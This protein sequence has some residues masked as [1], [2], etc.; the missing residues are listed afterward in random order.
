MKQRLGSLIFISVFATAVGAADNWPEYRGPTADGHSDAT[1]LPLHWS[2]TENIAWKTPIHD[3]GWS[4]PV[5]WGNKIWLTT[6]TEDGKKYYALAIDAGTGKILHDIKLFEVENPEFCHPF[7]SYAS[8]TPAIEAGRVYV[9][10]GTYGTACLDSE[11]GK[12]IWT[13]RDLH[14]DHF[15]GPASSPILD[16]ER[17]YVNFDGI[18][19]EYVVALD[20]ATGRTVWKRER[21]IDYGTTVG[22]LK[23][24]YSTPMLLK[25]ESGTQLISPAAAATI[26]YDPATGSELWRVRHGGMN[27][28]A[29]PLAGFGLVFLCAGDGGA[30]P[31]V[32]VRPGGEIVWKQSKGVPARASLL[33]VDD[34]LFMAS[35]KR[36]ATCL[37]ARTGQVIWQKRLNT[38]FIASPVYADHRIY[39][40]ATD[41]SGLVFKPG[42]E[43][44]VLATNHLNDGCM[45]SPAITGK[46]LI[47][48]TKTHLYRIE[49]KEKNKG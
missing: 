9:H 6:A 14:C 26:A 22:D 42:R 21:D 11:T 36:I 19:A 40:F 34:L 3:K 46:A 31:L 10:F 17:L 48:R 23:K 49:E 16:D 27:T 43:E 33:L 18:D 35:D 41:G 2:E 12:T 5:I 15:R 13:R 20:K 45:A 38:D 44:K 4:S 24:A 8:P 47:V 37:D 39:C 28:S 7:N 30:F 32:A 29:R 25:T 1:G